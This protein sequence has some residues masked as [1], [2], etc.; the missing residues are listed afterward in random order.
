MKKFVILTLALAVIALFAMPKGTSAAP[1]FITKGDYQVFGTMNDNVVDMNSDT[2]DHAAYVTQRFR[3]TNIAIMKDVKGFFLI[4]VGWDEWGKSYG[5][6]GGGAGES[7]HQGADTGVSSDMSNNNIEVRAAWIDF[8]LPG[9]PLSVS[10]GKQFLYTHNHTVISAAGAVPSLQLTY[11]L[12]KGMDLKA[13][14]VKIQEGT[15]SDAVLR[16]NGDDDNDLYALDFTMKNKTYEFGAYGVWNRM[17]TDNMVVAASSTPT[18]FV[19]PTAYTD[20]IYWI[21]V[22]AGFTIGPVKVGFD[23][24]YDFGTRDFTTSGVQDQDYSGYYLRADATMTLGGVKLDFLTMYAS[25]DNDSTDNTMN[26]YATAR[27]TCKYPSMGLFLPG[28]N[29]FYW[30]NGIAAEDFTQA[31]LPVSGWGL[32]DGTPPGNPFNTTALGRWLTMLGASYPIDKWTVIGKYWY[33][34]T[35]QDF[36]SSVM[37]RSKEIGHE[38]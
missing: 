31:C 17:R 5:I 27:N 4:E 29:I 20:D 25:G 11:N 8:T 10:V 37:Y 15:S 12:A 1:I 3:L 26:Q 24:I 18:P 36:P 7:W 19:M 35:A 22:W 33:M 30:G 34:Q 14:W 32:Y 28:P 6:Q 16:G 9:T 13:W 21:G 38:I 2:D 23:A